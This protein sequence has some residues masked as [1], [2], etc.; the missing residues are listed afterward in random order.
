MRNRIKEFR[1]MKASEILAH[2]ENWRQH[3][4]KQK[5]ALRAVLNEIGYAN[6]V[7]AY[8]SA[9]GLRL[10]DGH[11]RRDVAGDEEIPV[12][13]TDLSE[14]EARAAL[15][16]LDPLAMMADSQ[17]DLLT[18]LAKDLKEFES[19]N[20]V[21]TAL[22]DGHGGGETPAGFDP[23]TYDTDF[24]YKTQYAVTVICQDEAEQESVYSELLARGYNVKVV[25][26]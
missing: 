11:L 24:S 4:P 13:V 26:T 6:A 21:L 18:A 8:E 23:L 20:E 15:A 12:L 3:P 2:P 17:M 14:D 25:V 1:V 19:V 22:V 5:K 16:T 7:I 9:E 10:I